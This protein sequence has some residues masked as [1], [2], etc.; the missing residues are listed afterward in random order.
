MKRLNLRLCSFMAILCVLMSLVPQK[1][2]AESPSMMDL[3]NESGYEAEE[4]NQ[5]KSA[6]LIDANTG[7]Y[8]WSENPDVSRNPA[9]I[10]KLLVVYLTY[11]AIREGKIS[12]ET[13]VTAT[14]RHAAISQIYELSNSKIVEGVSYPVKELFPMV[15]V[16]S[17]N[18]AT[19]MLSELVEN[20]PVAFI[21][22]MNEKAQE[23]GMENTTI[24]NAT[25]AQISAFQGLYAEEGVDISALQPTTD[26]VSTAKD[27]AVF[28]YHL[29]DNFP[30]VL[31][32]SN[33]SQVTVMAGTPYEQTFD[34]YNHSLPGAAHDYEGVD[35]L[36][37][38]S[39]ESGGFNI[40]MTAKRGDLR[41]IAVVLGVG[42]WSDQNGEYYRHPFANAMMDYG[43]NHFE[44]KELLPAGK[45]QVNEENIVLSDTVWDLVPKGETPGFN[46]GE[47]DLLEVEN[48]LAPASPTI[49][50]VKVPFEREKSI[51]NK[52]DLSAL[53]NKDASLGEKVFKTVFDNLLLLISI[54]ALIALIILVIVTKVAANRRKKRRQMTR[55]SRG[56]R[57]R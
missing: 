55:Q 22:K 4:Y 47:D 23:L 51:I 43:F 8:L 39:S 56:R 6:F 34:S 48:S 57:S 2:Y 50:P 37:T 7:K 52:M 30:E 12:L 15:F 45:Q 26:N 17:S 21:S 9:S 31:E 42:D 11:E 40:S 14:R 29:L 19:I 41:M 38:G 18:V 3:I 27:V 46:L 35:G 24:Y 5:P 16:P 25:G 33:R 13:E 44:Y 20:D 10:I 54:L 1:V 53:D 49:S 32:Y 28:T 36:K